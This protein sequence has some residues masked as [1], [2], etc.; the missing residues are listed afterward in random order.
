MNT[1]YITPSKL[2]QLKSKRVKC[3][4]ADRIDPD[5][6]VTAYLATRKPGDTVTL[7]PGKGISDTRYLSTAMS[8]LHDLTLREL[9]PEQ[10]RDYK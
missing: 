9:T 10:M 7:Y 3:T 2:K 1:L 5:L 6:Q 4:N 8:Y